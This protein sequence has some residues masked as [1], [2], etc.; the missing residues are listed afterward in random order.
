MELSGKTKFPIGPPSQDEDILYIF[1]NASWPLQRMEEIE[2]RKN[3]DL[4]KKKFR[5]MTKGKSILSNIAITNK[6]NVNV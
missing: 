5:F 4:R 6:L 3:R 1:M 2:K